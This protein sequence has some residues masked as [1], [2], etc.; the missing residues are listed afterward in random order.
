MTPAAWR[1]EPSNGIDGDVDDKKA[2][3]KC[4]DL[5][6]GKVLWTS[7]EA[8]TGEE[9]RDAEA[10]GVAEEQQARPRGAPLGRREGQHACEDRPDAGRPSGGKRDPDE[11][12]PQIAR[13]AIAEL[14]PVLHLQEVQVQHA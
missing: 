11:E 1:F 14:I 4:L 8:E 12:R 2:H 7:P 10:E 13:R 5:A 6:T 9:E 3:L